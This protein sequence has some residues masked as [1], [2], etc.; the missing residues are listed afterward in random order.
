MRRVV[1]AALVTL[2]IA[3][4]RHPVDRADR[5][6]KGPAMGGLT[7]AWEVKSRFRLFRYERDYRRHVAAD[8]G[9]GILAAEQRLAAETDGRGWARTMVTSLC[10]DASGK[11]LDTCERDG[12]KESYLA[13][14][15][16]RV[17]AMVQNAPAGATCT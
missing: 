2:L 4:R 6:S 16:H 5:Q 15:D 13:P 3:K 17:G 1:L 10:V 9:D 11:L 7:I 12:E 14:V 8:R